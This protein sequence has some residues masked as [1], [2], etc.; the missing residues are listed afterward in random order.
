MVPAEA[1]CP[2]TDLDG[3]DALPTASVLLQRPPTLLRGL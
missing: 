3:L 2:L 1:V